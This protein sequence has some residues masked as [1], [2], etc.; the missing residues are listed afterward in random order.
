MTDMQLPPS[1]DRPEW[2]PPDWPDERE[3]PDDRELDRLVD[4]ELEPE[5]RER[6]LRRLDVVPDG[7]KRCALAFL[8]AQAW[9]QT[10]QAL[11]RPPDDA[12][13]AP[14]VDAAVDPHAGA[15]WRLGAGRPR[16]RSLTVAAA[17]VLVAFVAGRQTT[18]WSSRTATQSTPSVSRSVGGG[19]PVADAQPKQLPLWHLVVDGPDGRTALPVYA[20]ESSLR[21][22]EDW[23]SA[24]PWRGLEQDGHAVRQV[25]RWYTVGL[26]NGRQIAVPIEEVEL[27]AESFVALSGI[28]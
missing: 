15:G 6:L 22:G 17:A 2:L 21:P 8:E 18:T 28:Q 23:P 19:F 27:D 10:M 4:D 11:C 14:A 13:V 12:S 1:S 26:E 24:S 9:Q 20:A 5:Q 7:W 3:W 25:R 16:W